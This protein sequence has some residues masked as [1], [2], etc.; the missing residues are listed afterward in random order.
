MD[1][2]LF[3]LSALMALITGSF[4]TQAVAQSFVELD[5]IRYDVSDD[6]KSAYA[7]GSRPGIRDALIRSE[8]TISGNNYPV[9]VISSFFNQDS[10]RHVSIPASVN[11]IEA[12][13]FS[14][15]INLSEIVIPPTVDSI[16]HNVFDSCVNLK[17]VYLPDNLSSMGNGVFGQ[18]CALESIAIPNSMT[19]IPPET[20]SE[21]SGLRN[22]SIPSSVKT[23]GVAAFQYCSSLPE[24]RLPDSLTTIGWHAFRNCTSLTSVE[25]PD[26]V[27]SIGF[28][29]F[30]ECSNLTEV[31]IGKSVTSI[32]G[33]AFDHTGLVSVLIPA[34]VTSIGVDAFAWTPVKDLYCAPTVPP[35]AESPIVTNE[36]NVTLHVP[37]GCKEAY[38]KA[39]TW[40]R[41]R[42]IVEDPELS[43]IETVETDS[44]AP[45]TIY[46]DLQG[47]EV[48]NPDA[49]IYL[50]RQGKAVEKVVL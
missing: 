17:K 33:H 25:I 13:A 49:G 24:V 18:C 10:L 14:H 31:T 19:T 8:V 32:G 41:F 4:S 42:N 43:G 1:R 50:R 7:S 28:C 46:Y 5:S 15:C 40:K 26:S 2:F 37:V 3:T 16:G 20:F 30:I 47:R 45:Q 48:K 36:V 35:T 11:L 9:T 21:C 29:V 34:S 27:T 38:S 44:V 12:G 6:G 39:T 22:V 23:I